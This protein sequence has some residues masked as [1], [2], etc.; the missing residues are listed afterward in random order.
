MNSNYLK[1]IKVINKYW[2]Y[3]RKKKQLI[4]NS[5]QKHD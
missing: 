5:L 1:E 2:N 3:K 4:N